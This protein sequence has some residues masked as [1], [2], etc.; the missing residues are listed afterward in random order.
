MRKEQEGYVAADDISRIA[1]LGRVALLFFFI[2]LGSK[3]LF[4]E[5]KTIRANQ[6]AGFAV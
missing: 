3:K 1:I 4:I 6:H 5:M 2:S